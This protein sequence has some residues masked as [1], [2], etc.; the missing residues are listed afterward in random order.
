MLNPRYFR[1]DINEAAEKLRKRGYELDVKSITKFEKQRKALQVDTE[2]LQGERNSISKT[3]GQAKAKGED[4]KDLFDKVNKLNEKLEAKQAEL[5]KIQLKLREIQDDVPNIPHESV[6]EGKSE[7][8]N[9]EVRKWGELRKFDFEVKD[10]IEL[11]EKLKKLD[12]KKASKISGARFVV[13]YGALARLQRALTQFMIDVQT[14]E[15]GYQE[16]YAPYIVNGK[17]L[18]A[19]GQLPKFEAEL[20]SLKGDDDYWLIPTAEVPVT[21]VVRDEIIEAEDLPLKFACHTPCFR[22]EAGSYGK[23]TRGLIRQHQFEK[24]EMVWISRPEDS[25]D[26]LEEITKNAETILQKLKIP[27]RVVALCGGDMGFLGA[28]SR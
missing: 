23:D 9:V 25:Y 3:I 27:Y 6:P 16:I 4:A 12:F 26:A 28:S 1:E 24:V 18:Y 10:H 13:L 11:G 17:S 7:D 2:T 19:T 5:D 22:S 8:D 14:E 21:N 20:F 15:H